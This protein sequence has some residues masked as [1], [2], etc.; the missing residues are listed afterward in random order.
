MATYPDADSLIEKEPMKTHLNIS[1]TRN[2]GHP[3]N[4]PLRVAVELNRHGFVLE[5]AYLQ[6]RFPVFAYLQESVLLAQVQPPDKF[7]RLLPRIAA[8]LSC[9][10]VMTRTPDAPPHPRSWLITSDGIQAFERND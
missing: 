2:D 9:N 8:T 7:M 3:D 4:S 6:G 5:D 1:L 10:I